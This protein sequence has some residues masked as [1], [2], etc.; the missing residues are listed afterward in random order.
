MATEFEEVDEISQSSNRTI[1]LNNLFHIFVEEDPSL[2]DRDVGES[3][4]D[5]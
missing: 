3:S 1:E 2:F 5:K 4:E